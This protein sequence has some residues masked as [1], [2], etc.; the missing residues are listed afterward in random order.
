MPPTLLNLCARLE[1]HDL[2]RR[3]LVIACNNFSDWDE[4]LNRAE[5]Q[6]MGPLLFRHLAGI[7]GEVPA[8]FLR[9]LRF[10]VLR[11]HQAN[12]LLMRSLGNVLSLLEEEG[13]PSFVLKGG[14]LC[15]TLYPEVGLR[16]MRDIDLLL[17]GEDAQRGHLLLQK[18][19]FR[20][21]AAV[22]PEDYFHLVP[23]I[24]NIDGMDVCVELH[25]GLFPDDPPYY[26]PLS[27]TELYRGALSF[28]VDGVRAYTLADEE[29]LWHLFQHGFHAPLTY[30]PYKLISVADI[31]SLVEHKV[32]ELDWE[33]IMAVYP[34]LF[35][36][37]PFF[38]HIT[39]WNKSVMSVVSCAEGAALSAV[40]E[41]YRG[42]PRSRFIEQTDKGILLLLRDTFFPGQWWMGLYY[43]IEGPL[44]SVWARLVR[45]PMH[46]L[47]WIKIY[48][49]LFLGEKRRS[50]TGAGKK[51]E[52]RP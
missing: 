15:Q 36:A 9:G 34:Q 52:P 4:L 25:H 37:L 39:P 17:S 47:R 13:I 24:Q 29:M 42:W 19:G 18:N 33:K 40:G 12:I 11:H 35:R 48:G 14:A 46:I 41:P 43:S 26:R 23:L 30:E 49:A 20:P 22:L 5:E 8:T 21:S 31:V 3:H 6:G 16:P 44:S 1:S 10:I 32:E 51:Q 7:E 28:E 38:H 50:V 27:F 2:Q 45:H